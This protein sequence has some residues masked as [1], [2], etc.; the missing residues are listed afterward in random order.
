M[1]PGLAIFGG[2]PVVGGSCVVA[3]LSVSEA[4]RSRLS[5]QLGV[6]IVPTGAPS[7]A[8]SGMTA[9]LAYNI[10]KQ[11]LVQLPLF[12]EGGVFQAPS[13]IKSWTDFWRAT[14]PRAGAT[15]I[16]LIGAGAV[17]GAIAPHFDVGLGGT[18]E[19]KARPP[20]LAQT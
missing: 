19:R 9:V 5:S 8:L 1:C 16:A 18:R 10:Q 7:L 15:V 2:I 20:A 11:A 4:S 14:G 13:T 12:S 3:F 6:D 17:A